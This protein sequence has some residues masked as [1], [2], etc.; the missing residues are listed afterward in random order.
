VSCVQIDP[1][2]VTV[3]V[4]DFIKHDGYL[5]RI[6]T[7]LRLLHEH[8]QQIRDRKLILVLPDGEPISFTAL[9]RVLEIIVQNHGLS[10]DRVICH[11]V[12]HYP[13]FESEWCAVETYPTPFFQQTAE[14]LRIDLCRVDEDA[15]LFGAAYGRFMPS[16]LLMAHFLVT[17]FPNDSFVIFQ[18]GQD[19][20]E[21]EMAPGD[22]IF[23]DA[24]DWAACRTHHHDLASHFN[25]CVSSLACLPVYHELFGR[26]RIEIVI[27]TNTYSE[28][29]FTEKT[30]KCLAAGKPFLLYGTSGQLQQLRT[31]GFRTFGDYIDESY[32]CEHDPDIRFDKICAAVTAIHEHAQ[33]NQLL[34]DL[35]TIAQWNR[36]HYH[37]IIENYYHD[38]NH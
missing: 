38:F 15:K 17:H 33:Q 36:Q 37:R 21:F 8:R 35:G 26:Y 24:V 1:H 18:P 22:E 34:A 5:Y 30:A 4:N 11:M 32:D 23:Q 2:A 7:L 25:G 29:W 6:G 9:D 16:R 12:D 20:V 31:M 3:V 19:F 13:R 27:E 28:G 10:P 14:L